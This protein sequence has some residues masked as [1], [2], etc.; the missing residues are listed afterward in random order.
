[1]D[2]EGSNSLERAA[3]GEIIEKRLTS[4]A[5]SLSDILLINIK[6]DQISQRAN[7]V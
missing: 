6:T 7:G 4:L 5:I 1:M 3:D 2:I